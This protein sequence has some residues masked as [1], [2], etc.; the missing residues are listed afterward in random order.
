[1]DDISK[2]NY[3][4]LPNKEKFYSM[5]NNDNVSNEDCKQAQNIW[6]KFNCKTFRDY[7]MLY[8]KSDTLLLADVFENFRTTCLDT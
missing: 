1:M 2:F 6:T 7:H 8:L 3:E 5:L 4:K